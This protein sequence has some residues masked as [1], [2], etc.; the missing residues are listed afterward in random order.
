MPPAPPPPTHPFSLGAAKGR[1]GL[2]IR[3]SASRDSIYS[4]QCPPP[5]SPS[6]LRKAPQLFFFK[7]PHL[8]SFLT[9]PSFFR[10]CYLHPVKYL[11]L[12]ADLPTSLMHAVAIS[13]NNSPCIPQLQGRRGPLALRA[14]LSLLPPFLE[15]YISPPSCRDGGGDEGF[16]LYL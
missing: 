10:R 3:A 14:S 9:W 7:S 2:F 15:I 4:G 13:L 1:W 12:Q 16:Y 5:P 11:Y 8:H 6:H